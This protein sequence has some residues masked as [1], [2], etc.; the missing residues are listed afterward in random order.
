MILFYN[1]IVEKSIAKCDKMRKIMQKYLE[2]V[3]TN[4]CK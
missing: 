1:I 2:M 4:A 3:L